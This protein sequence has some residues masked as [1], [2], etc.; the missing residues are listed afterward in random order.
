MSRP[1]ST[2][3][4]YSAHPT[5]IGGRPAIAEICRRMKMVTALARMAWTT[6][7]G[8]PSRDPHCGPEA[9]WWRAVG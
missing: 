7:Y 8:K 3:A 9:T 6:D 5:T 2:C 4:E 1:C